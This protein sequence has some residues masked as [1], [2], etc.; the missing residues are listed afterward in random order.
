MVILNG[1]LVAERSVEPHYVAKWNRE[2]KHTSLS[3]CIQRVRF[4]RHILK[5]LREQKEAT[6]VF[7]DKKSC[8]AW[9]TEHG[10][11]TRTLRYATTLVG[12]RQ[13]TIKSAWIT[14]LRLK[15]ANFS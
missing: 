7:E 4:H 3:K 10:K 9:E 5:E 13:S 6:V 8:I 15:I 2:A 1:Y 11:H 14:S 12:K